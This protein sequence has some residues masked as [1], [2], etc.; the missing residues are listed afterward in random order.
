M[1]ILSKKENTM[2]ELWD[3]YDK[4]RNRTGKIHRRGEPLAEG[5]YHLVVHIWVRDNQGN[6]L[7]TKRA[8]DKK[9]FPGCW[10]CTGGSALAGETSLD[11]AL[12]ETMEET[13][14]DHSNAKKTCVIS[15]RRD[16]W[17]GDVW[18][19]ESDFSLSDVILQENETTDKKLVNKETVLAM[20]KSGEFCGYDYIE[21]F[22]SKV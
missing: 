5:E 10:E 13:G 4:D 18:L 15:Y 16:D 9:P 22:M 17:F 2:T 1:L 21:D 14:L 12:R 20:L 19:F 11:A 8:E 6:F 7:I 3:V